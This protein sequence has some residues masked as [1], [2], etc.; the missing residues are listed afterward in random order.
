MTYVTEF[1]EISM[2]RKSNRLHGIGLLFLNRHWSRQLKH[3]D[4][5]IVKFCDT[6]NAMSTLLKFLSDHSTPLFYDDNLLLC[7]WVD[8]MLQA[9]IQNDLFLIDHWTEYSQSESGRKRERGRQ[10][11]LI[12]LAFMCTEFNTPKK[13]VEVWVHPNEISSKVRSHFLY[14]PMFGSIVFD[15]GH[16]LSN[17]LLAHTLARTARAHIHQ[18]DLT[19]NRKSTF[20]TI[21]IWNLN[22]W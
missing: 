20:S 16:L 4:G 7:V 11:L 18:I 15:R 13:N 21:W 12:H 17:A 3:H 22:G 9:D 5:H 1:T 14:F 2:I 6:Q 8:Q 10:R 19:A